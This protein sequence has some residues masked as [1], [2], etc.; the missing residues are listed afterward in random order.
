MPKDEG[1]HS[2][3]VAVPAVTPEGRRLRGK[4]YGKFRGEVV[5]NRD[6]LKMGRIRAKVPDLFGDQETPWALPC[7]PFGGD[8][9]GFFAILPVGAKVWVEFEQGDVNSPIWTG[10]W[11][12]SSDEIP[13]VILSSP[14]TKTAIVTGGGQR[15]T[16]DDAPGSEGISLEAPGGQKIE[17]TTDGITIDNGSGAKIE[18]SNSLV[19]IN[20]GMFEVT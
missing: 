4:A 5:N 20:D 9:I 11:W 13:S 1:T 6:P 14:Y 10:C 2:G 3:N 17:I 8:R 7:M 15:I 19:K 12:G 18:L 16:L